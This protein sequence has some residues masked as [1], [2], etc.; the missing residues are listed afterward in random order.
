MLMSKEREVEKSLP[1]LFLC[2]LQ[3]QCLWYRA[4]DFFGQ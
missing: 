3:S 2:I 4:P 1:E